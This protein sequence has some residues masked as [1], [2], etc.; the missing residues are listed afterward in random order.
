MIRREGMVDYHAFVRI[1]DIGV[2]LQRDALLMSLDISNIAG[3]PIDAVTVRISARDGGGQKLLIEGADSHLFPLK[4]LGL[5]AATRIV[6]SHRCDVTGTPAGIEAEVEE[7]VFSDGAIAEKQ[8]PHK[9]LYYYSTFDAE[10]PR[11]KELQD[12]LRRYSDKAVCFAEKRNDGWLCS[13]GRLNRNR[14]DRCPECL[15]ERKELFFHCTKEAIKEEVKKERGS[16]FSL[17]PF[18]I[19][20]I[21]NRVKK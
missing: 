6:V 2:R 5:E 19:S 4:N 3:R 1:N 8:K 7:V 20:D 11:E 21:M 14:D 9:K 13:C 17:K 12:C 16:V 15:S 10:K 18:S